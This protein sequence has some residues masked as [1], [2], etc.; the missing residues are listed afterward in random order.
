MIPTQYWD[1]TIQKLSEKQRNHLA[2]EIKQHAIDWA[3]AEASVQEIDTVNIFM[4]ACWP[5]ADCRKIAA[6]RKKFLWMVCIARIPAYQA[7][8]L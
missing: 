8:L 3:I 4:P 2:L 5:C 1:W 6:A 7:V